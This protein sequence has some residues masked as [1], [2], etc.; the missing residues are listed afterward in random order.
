MTPLATVQ[1]EA[2]R[3]DSAKAT[4]H[5]LVD[6]NWLNPYPGH[7]A[8]GGSWTLTLEAS[9]VAAKGDT[10]LLRVLADSVERMGRQS[11][12]GRSPGL[13]HYLPGLLLVRQ[14]RHAQA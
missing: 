9:A 8:R 1:F 3:Y 11:L 7:R 2:Q 14:G 5:W 12:F 4:Y 13:H 10:A 6:Q